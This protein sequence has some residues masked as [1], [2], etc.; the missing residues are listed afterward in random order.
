MT[1]T[2]NGL[3]LN[4]GNLSR[5][6]NAETRSISFMPSLTRTLFHLQFDWSTAV[7]QPATD[8]TPGV[9]VRTATQH[10]VSGVSL[11]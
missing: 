11:K 5:V 2:Y 4:L 3:G 6:S 9:R 1:Y 8:T 7:L 10:D